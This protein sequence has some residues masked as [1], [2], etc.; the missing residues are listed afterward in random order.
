MYFK[1]RTIAS[2]ICCSLI[3]G[4]YLKSCKIHNSEIPLESFRLQT[5]IVFKCCSIILIKYRP[6]SLPYI[7][8]LRINYSD[9]MIIRNWVISFQLVRKKVVYKTILDCVCCC[10]SRSV[11]PKLAQKLL[12]PCYK[13]AHYVWVKPEQMH[14]KLFWNQLWFWHKLLFL[15]KV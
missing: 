12:D 6:I 1:N 5:V 7:Y 3:V 4:M 9:R 14:E 8:F 13:Y 2:S 11:N 15:P 10:S